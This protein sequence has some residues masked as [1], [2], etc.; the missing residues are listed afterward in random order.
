MDPEAAGSSLP[1]EKAPGGTAARAPAPAGAR[2]PSAWGLL[3]DAGV[4]EGVA[5][6]ATYRPASSVRFFAGPAWNY[7]GFGV[8]GGVSIVPWHFAVTPVLTAEAGRYF[9]E[10]VSFIARSGSGVPP[11]LRPLMKDMTYTYGAVH[12]GIELGSQRGFAWSIAAG[13]A[14]VSLETKGT[15]TQTDGTG[16]TVTFRDPRV[17]ATLPSLKLGLHYWF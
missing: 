4:P 9:G 12:V 11:E 16:T 6:S 14:W 13:L 15:V 2:G 1:P 17:R 10:D 5:L 8:Q 3:L 7:V